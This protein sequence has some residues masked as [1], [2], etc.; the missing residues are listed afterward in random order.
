MTISLENITRNQEL[1]AGEVEPFSANVK[2][3]QRNDVEVAPVL[4]NVK[5]A[6]RNDA[7]VEP[8]LANVKYAQRNDEEV[9][10]IAEAA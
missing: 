2:Y 5:Y 4:A 9:M 7:E 1:T 10:A 8:V 3:A 6:Q